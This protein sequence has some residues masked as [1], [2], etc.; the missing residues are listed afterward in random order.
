MRFNQRF[1]K[2]QTGGKTNAGVGDI[3]R[4]PVIAADLKVQKIDHMPQSEA[5]T[6]ISD[7]PGE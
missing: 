6:D 3:E 2:K 4:R 5:I 7:D 1:Q